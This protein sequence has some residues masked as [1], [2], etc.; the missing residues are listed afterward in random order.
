MR[1]Q[2][3]ERATSILNAATVLA[4]RP[5]GLFTLTRGLVAQRAKC[6]PGLVSYYFRDMTNLRSHV[7]HAAVATNNLIIIAQALVF[8]LPEVN[9]LSHTFKQKALVSLL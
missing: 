3:D 1:Q 9:T 4:E 2:P 7:I 6:A 8:N 5:G